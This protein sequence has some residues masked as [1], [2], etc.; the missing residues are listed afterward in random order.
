MSYNVNT[1]RTGDIS[2]GY[3]FSLEPRK[4]V[5]VTYR[6]TNNADAIKKEGSNVYY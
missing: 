3:S 5:P 6:W 4:N 1:V 2:G